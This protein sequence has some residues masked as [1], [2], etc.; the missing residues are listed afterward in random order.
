P[1][2]LS[3]AMVSL[4]GLRFSSHYLNPSLRGDQRALM[5]LVKKVSPGVVTVT[6]H[7]TDRG[8]QLVLNPPTLGDIL[9]GKI[10]PKTYDPKKIID[11]PTGD[12]GSGFIVGRDELGRPLII[13]NAHVVDPLGRNGKSSVEFQGA[14]VPVDIVSATMTVTTADGSTYAA[15]LIGYSD[16]TSGYDLA[17]VRM[18]AQCPDCHILKLGVDDKVAAGEFVVAMG[19]PLGLSG[20]TTFGIVS[21]ADRKAQGFISALVGNYIQT[22]APINP[23]NSGGPLINISG[24]VIGVNEWIASQSGGSVGLGFAIPIRFVQG[25]LNR[26][27]TTNV[28]DSADPGLAVQATK[29]GVLK[30]TSI[31]ENLKSQGLKVGD[32]ISTVDN[33]TFA[34]PISLMRY[35]ANKTPGSTAVFDVIR[36]GYGADII[37]TLGML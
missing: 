26:Y 15:T 27:H 7:V 33:Q 18:D 35:L 17:L 13:T 30:I 21:N 20:T 5:R 6:I 25:M 4:H 14:S 32:L 1:L 37:V 12:L 29:L 10:D 24:K 8:P 28:F 23:G 2:S 19:A 31:S 9:S 16:K 11:K 22:D 3:E 36:N 34:A